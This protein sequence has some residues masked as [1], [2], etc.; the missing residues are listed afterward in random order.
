MIYLLRT[1]D[2]PVGIQ[3]YSQIMIG[4]LNFLATSGT[5][6][7]SLSS[8]FPSRIRRSS[9]FWIL[10]ISSSDAF[11]AH[12]F[13]RGQ[14]RSD[15]SSPQVSHFLEV[16]KLSSSY[17][18]QFIHVVIEVLVLLPTKV[19]PPLFCMQLT[20]GTLQLLGSHHAIGANCKKGP[21]SKSPA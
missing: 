15:D 16:S 6:S 14:R 21:T 18:H 11:L 12:R 20:K 19:H 7:T 3:S 5:T 17:S 8:S 13:L 1:M 10:L 4:V 2:I 9:T